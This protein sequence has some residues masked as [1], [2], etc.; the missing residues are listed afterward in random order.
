MKIAVT[1]A[2]GFVGSALVPSLRTAGHDVVMLVR[3]EPAD[4][5]E[6]RWDPAA[7][8]IDTARLR[9]VDAVVHLAGEPLD[10]R[11]TKRVRNRLVASRVDGTA[12]LART[13]AALE[14]RPAVLVQASG[15]GFY[16]FDSQTVT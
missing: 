4:E 7:E 6:I 3:R 5:A 2:S 12:F 11:W 13:L 15:I 8:A 1:G 10:R 9:G 16:G 14:P